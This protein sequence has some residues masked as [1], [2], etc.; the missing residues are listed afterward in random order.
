MRLLTMRILDAKNNFKD[1]LLKEWTDGV[2][3]S[4]LNL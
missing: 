4:V 2:R 3:Q 1:F